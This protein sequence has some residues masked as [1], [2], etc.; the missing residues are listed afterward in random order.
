MSEESKYLKLARAAR[1]E[2]NGEDA[3]KFYDMVRTDDPE[4]GEAKFFYQFYSMYEGKNGELASR[5]SKLVNVLDSSVKF[6]SLSADSENEKMALLKSIV[7]SFTPMT[8]STR[9]YMNGLVV[10]SAS[11]QSTKVLPG[12]DFTLVMCS[13]ISG[14]YS[15]GDAIAK[16][17]PKNAEAMKLA[18]TP[19]KEGVFLHQKWFWMV[20][21]LT[22]KPED[23]SSKIQKIESSYDMPK[24]ANWCANTPDKR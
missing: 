21:S 12:S 1:D 9:Q 14:L 3:K 6:I 18:V 2:S 8:W 7:D 19:W 20:K 4:N 5:F 11:G 24:R 15:L 16:Y 13:G 23:Y 22:T 10:K 17:F